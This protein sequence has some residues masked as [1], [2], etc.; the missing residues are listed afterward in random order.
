MSFIRMLEK[1]KR[2]QTMRGI[3]IAFLYS[4]TK[5]R[6]FFKQ[7]LINAAFNVQQCGIN[8]GI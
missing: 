1:M 7:K 8:I 5:K 6:I 4:L 3:Q 2:R